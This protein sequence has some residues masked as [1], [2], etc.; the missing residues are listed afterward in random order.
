MFILYNFVSSCLYSSTCWGRFLT[1]FMI[2]K[3]E[4]GAENLI[5]LICKNLC[6][7]SLS[8]VFVLSPGTDSRAWRVRKGGWGRK[9]RKEVKAVH[10]YLASH[11][12]T[13]RHSHCSD[14]G[15]QKQSSWQSPCL[16]PKG[17]AGMKRGE[18]ICQLSVSFLSMGKVS[19]SELCHSNIPGSCWESLGSLDSAGLDL[20][21]ATTVASVWHTDQGRSC[22]GGW[23]SR[24]VRRC[25]SVSGGGK[26]LQIQA[27]AFTGLAE[28]ATSTVNH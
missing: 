27:D 11:R 15:C 9:E 23:G 4:R 16:S 22:L 14:A 28:D 5:L 12:F 20:T 7:Q 25:G 13:G 19:A 26:A 10:G 8:W 21:A 18:P 6:S 2:W 24:A 3:Y 17:Q 1:T